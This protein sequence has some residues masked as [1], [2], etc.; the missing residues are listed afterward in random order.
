MFYVLRG[1]L[2]WTFYINLLQPLL[3]DTSLVN[4]PHVLDGY[5][6]CSCDYTQVTVTAFARSAKFLFKLLVLLVDGQAYLCRYLFQACGLVL[7]LPVAVKQESQVIC[8][9]LCL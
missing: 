5:W 8:P 6:G 7:H 4:A 1:F 3:H 2:P 9:K